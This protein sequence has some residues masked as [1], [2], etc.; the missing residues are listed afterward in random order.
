VESG[1]SASDQPSSSDEGVTHTIKS[2]DDVPAGDTS[3]ALEIAFFGFAKAN[4]YTSAVYQG[5]EAY[6]EKHNAKTTFFDPNFDAQTQVSQIQDAV[7]SGRYDVF[8]VLANDGTAVVPAVE[9]AVSAG[10]TVV[11]LFAPVGSRYDTAEPQ[12]AGTINLVDPPTDNGKLLG[13]LGADAC[14]E[15]GA[16][17]CKVAYLEG[18]KALPLDNARTETVKSVLEEAGAEV[19]MSVEGG[20]TTDQGREAMQDVL[21]AQPDVNVVLGSSQAIAGAASVAGADSD[22]LFVGNGASIQALTAVKDGSWFATVCAPAV[23]AGETGAALG[24]AA[25]RGEDVPVATEYTDL[26]PVGSLCTADTVDQVE[27]EYVE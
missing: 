3:E 19:V 2:A 22:I 27:G 12:V 8:L 23:D 25:A 20:Y 11:V 6:A 9:D 21:Q 15:S 17:P 1:S 4:S 7:T 14:A 24:L 10:K 26:S 13:Q 18:F 16:D 5:A